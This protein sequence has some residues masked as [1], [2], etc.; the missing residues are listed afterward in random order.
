VARPVSLDPQTI[1]EIL[2][3]ADAGTPVSKICSAYQISPATYY[4]WRRAFARGNPS[5]IARIT[6]LERT[7]SLL[8]ARNERQA[9]EIEALRSVIRGNG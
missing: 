6:Q 4:R 1:V 3:K 5:L 8:R 7:V 9:N 2:A